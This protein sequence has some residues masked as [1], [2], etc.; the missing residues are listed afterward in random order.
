MNRIYKVARRVIWLTAAIVACIGCNPASLSYFLFKGDGKAPADYPLEPPEGR[1]DLVIA[2]LISAPNV[3]VEFAGIDRDLA[4][5]LGNIL[6]DQSKEKKPQI[7]VIDQS[8]IDRFKN[9][10]A[11]WKTLSPAEVGR[12]LNADYVIDASVSG[13]RLYEAGSS[14]YMYQGQGSVDA[15]VFECATGREHSKYFVNAKLEA[16]PSDSV[17]VNQYRQ[18]LVRR[19]ADEMS[20]KHLPHVSDRRVAPVQ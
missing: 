14:V 18:L 2:I 9:S 7:R 8:R 19:I 17:P 15:V 20:W 13:L 6:V 3:P 5:N 12:Q 11:G 10:T 16:K 4:R 1:K